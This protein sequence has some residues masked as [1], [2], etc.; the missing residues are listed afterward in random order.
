MSSTI[1]FPQFA[2][3]VMVAVF[4]M[5]FAACGDSND[6]S[7]TS[8]T[9]A[10]D[11]QTSD[12][13][14]AADANAAPTMPAPQGNFA[15]VGEQSILTDTANLSQTTDSS[16]AAVDLS[17]GERAYTKNKCDSCHGAKGEG[18]ADKGKAIAGTTLSFEDFDKQLR[19][20][21]GLGNDHIFG[22]SAVSPKGMEAL[23]AFV[24]GLK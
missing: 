2:R 17:V 3:F 19:T 8:A 11:A 21:G 10:N 5:L 9:T 18:V 7:S 12:T 22:R 15:A 6:S 13:S 16:T 24:Q 14:A 23:Y 4:L 1:H 20:G